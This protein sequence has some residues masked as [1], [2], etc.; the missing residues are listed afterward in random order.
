MEHMSV[1]RH[2]HAREDGGFP[3]GRESQHERD[4]THGDVHGLTRAF[5]EPRRFRHQDGVEVRVLSRQ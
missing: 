4:S 5:R 3:P 1:D 2:G